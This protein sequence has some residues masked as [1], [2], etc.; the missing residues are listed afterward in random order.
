M[1]SIA[2]VMVNYR[3]PDLALQALDALAGERAANA[4][5]RVILVDGNSGDGSAEK[6]SRALAGPAYRDWV[7]LLPLGLNGG[8]GWG[9]N[10][11]MQR[12]LQSASPPDYIHLLN[13]D[14][15]VEPGAVGKLAAVLNVHPRCA[16][17]GS[18][19]LEPN[20]EPSGSAFTFP[21]IRT[22]L[23]RGLPM[24]IIV[25]LTRAKPLA[26]IGGEAQEVDW[27]TGASVMLRAEALREVGL[28]D[29]GFFLY[30][31]ET[32]L[33]WRLRRAGWSIR[34]EPASRVR[35]IGGSATGVNG[36]RIRELRPQLPS[37]WYASRRRFFGLTGSSAR[38]VAASSAYMVGHAVL[39]ARRALGSGRQHML[40][41]RD[42]RR[43][44]AHGIV[45]TARDRIPAIARWDDKIDQPPAWMG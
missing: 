19:L 44:I 10:Q 42:G 35:H 34:Y 23:L 28:F 14:A 9:N 7:T 15:Q 38:A 29:T 11:A 3:T 36:S 30:F 1:A 6:L 24:G 20:G 2:V 13:P 39:L 33:M 5:L 21:S 27:A 40:T 8:F 31:E 32:E 26:L 22:E 41:E 43:L 16:A 12:L 37:Y 4:G 18:L 45:P 17:V 25:R